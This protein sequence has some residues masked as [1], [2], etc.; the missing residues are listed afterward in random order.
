[1]TT[2]ATIGTLVW[3]SNPLVNEALR[4]C[5]EARV[6][7]GQALLLQ[8]IW[9]QEKDSYLPRREPARG[10]AIA[11]ADKA[12]E[13]YKTA[14]QLSDRLTEQ[15]RELY[16]QLADEAPE[17]ITDIENAVWPRHASIAHTESD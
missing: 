13:R 8:T 12:E 15:L 7:V 16:A 6:A 1:M 9:H 2:T 3:S 17:R 14:S 10:D 11:R 4:V 5:R